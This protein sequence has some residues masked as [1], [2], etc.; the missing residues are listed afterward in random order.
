MTPVETGE[1]GK[2]DRLGM[3]KAALERI[4]VGE[5]MAANG[6][7]ELIGYAGLALENLRESRDGGS[8]ELFSWVNVVF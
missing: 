3:W 4:V 7:F 6:G 8:E 2:S 5:K 1:E